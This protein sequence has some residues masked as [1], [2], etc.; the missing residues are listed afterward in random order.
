[1]IC[2]RGTAEEAMTAMRDMMTRLKLA[3]NERKTKLSQLPE[4]TFDF[5]GYTFGRY[6]SGKTGRAYL[7]PQ[8]SRKKIRKLCESLHERTSRRTM[9]LD[10]E[11]LVGQL[12]RQL[13]GW[14]NYFC[15]GPVHKAYRLVD[16]YLTGR[17]RRWLCRKHGLGSQNTTQYSYQYL[18]HELGLVH[19]PLQAAAFRVRKRDKRRL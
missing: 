18:Y 6:Y 2:C 16:R 9:Q 7:C 11:E 12:N 15:L 13:R 5:L 17:L 14:A 1:M 4:E 3:V 8:P 10:P 19:L